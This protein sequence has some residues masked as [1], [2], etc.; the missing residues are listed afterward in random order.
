MTTADSALI[1]PAPIATSDAIRR[2]AQLYVA[3]FLLGL[4]VLGIAVGLESRL[5]EA[6]GG[7]IIP[8]G[9]FPLVLRLRAVVATRPAWLPSA[10]VAIGL[11]GLLVDVVSVLERLVDPAPETVTMLSSISSVFM[12]LWFIALGVFAPVLPKRLQTWAI[13]GGIGALTWGVDF[14]VN[15]GASLTPFIAVGAILVWF[16]LALVVQLS[17]PWRGGA[18]V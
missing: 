9:E 2:A 13:L 15:P 11:A 4:A 3:T 18:R 14:L 7:V 10:I 8:I 16:S 5:I 1:G 6:L 17:R 12:G